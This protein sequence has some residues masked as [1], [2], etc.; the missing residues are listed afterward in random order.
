MA[1]FD[2]DDL[3]NIFNLSGVTGETRKE[4][5]RVAD[6]LA[7]EKEEEKLANKLPKKPKGEYVIVLKSPGEIPDNTVAAVFMIPN[8]EDPSLLLDSIRSATVTSNESQKKA[9]NK[10]SSFTDILFNLKPKFFK[11]NKRFT[12]EWLS[13]QVIT[14]EQDDK[15]INS[16]AKAE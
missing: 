14:P 2:H 4:A 3:I 15:F 5:L 8:G 9:K 10:L 1:K 16:P 12:K 13:V 11:P 7:K 6:M